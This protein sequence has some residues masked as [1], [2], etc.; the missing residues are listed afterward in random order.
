[1]IEDS[2]N[3]NK[4]AV[5]VIGYKRL[6]SIQ[7]LLKNLESA[8]YPDT[9]VPLIFSIDCGGNGELNKFVSEYHWPYGEKYV[10]IQKERLGL[11]KHIFTCAAR[12]R[13]FR[14]IILLEDDLAA[15]P[16]YYDY[17]VQ[18]LDAYENTPEIGEIALYSGIMNGFVNLPFFPLHRGA[19][20]FKLQYTCTWGECFTYRMWSEFEEWLAEWDGNFRTVELI[21]EIRGWEQAWSRYFHAYL[22]ATGKTVITPYTGLTT[23]TGEAGT[24]DCSIYRTPSPMELNQ[25]QYLMPPAEFL[26]AY[27]N[28]YNCMELHTA[29]GLGNELCLDLWGI[30]RER[31]TEN[32]TYQY[33]LSTKSYPYPVIKQWGAVLVPAELNILHNVPGNDIFL[34]DLRKN[35]KLV[36]GKFRLTAI[37]YFLRGFELRRLIWAVPLMAWKRIWL[38]TKK[39]LHITEEQ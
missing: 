5:T 19:D 15:A 20:V 8:S 4:V 18:A 2:E 23:P 29:L 30:G 3:L 26:T 24:H 34:Y 35:K 32:R 25:K 21:E 22:S 28:F 11:K 13:Y 31:M 38:K 12:S 27:D 36:K 33:L 10:F 39:I 6:D 9:G 1:M 16:G 7:R 37:E 17:T 14:G